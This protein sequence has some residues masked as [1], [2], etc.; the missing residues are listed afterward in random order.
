MV[1][2]VV[3]RDK[4]HLPPGT[5]MRLP[6]D[7]QLYRTLAD[8]LGK[9]SIPRIKYRRG[10][11]LLMAPSPEHGRDADIAADVIKVLLDRLNKDYTAFTP[12]T[13]DLPEEIGTEPDYCF[14]I[15]N[16]TA[17][18]GKNRIDWTVD[19]PPDLVV[20]VD[21]TSY[22]DIDDYLPYKVPEVWLFKRKNELQIY[23]YEQGNYVLKSESRFFPGINLQE[24]INDCSRLAREQNTRAALRELRRKLAQAD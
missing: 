9:R 11:I 18:A 21:V 8:Q 19:P 10:E 4:I 23:Q 6:G 2:A 1:F 13:L 3:S 15:D 5:V 24:L 12:I 17:I 22:T 14:Y 7:W 16:W 20:E